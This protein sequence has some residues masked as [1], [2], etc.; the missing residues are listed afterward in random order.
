[1]YVGLCSK[2]LH[3]QNEA[4]SSTS[5]SPGS[6]A[7]NSRPDKQIFARALSQS[8]SHWSRLQWTSFD[9]TNKKGNSSLPAWRSTLYCCKYVR[10]R[11]TWQAHGPP[12]PDVVSRLKYSA[13]VTV[14]CGSCLWQM[15]TKW[16]KDWWNTFLVPYSYTSSVAG[17]VLQKWLCLKRPQS[18]KGFVGTWKIRIPR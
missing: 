5:L 18:K 12:H 3:E 1:M 6:E 7:V 14:N 10:V 16:K 8:W 2:Q 13:A 15:Q 9:W 4:A 17:L 11:N